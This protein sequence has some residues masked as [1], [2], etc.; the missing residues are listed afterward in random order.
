MFQVYHDET[1]EETSELEFESESDEE[2]T[3]KNKKIYTLRT[4][5]IY[6]GKNLQQKEE[7]KVFRIKNTNTKPNV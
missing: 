2:S 3:L 7:E 5:L 6:K 4:F 1:Q